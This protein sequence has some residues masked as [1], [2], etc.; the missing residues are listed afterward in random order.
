MSIAEDYKIISRLGSQ[1]RRKFGDVFLGE[2]KN[3]GR[4]VVIKAVA[5]QNNQI[6]VDRLR[7]EIS[8]SFN[9]QG[10][11]KVIDS[12]EN[13]NELF[14]VK[15]YA[16]GI[17][18]D[19]FWDKL[20]RQQ[21]IGMLKTIAPK[22]L[23]LLEILKNK[24][25]VHGDL[26]PGNILIDENDLSVHLIDFGLAIDTSQIE[27]RE[28]LFPLGFA[29]PEL[30]LNQ[31][32]LVDH[33]TDQFAFGII[34]WRLFA[35]TLPLTHPNPSIFTNLQ[36]TH[37]LPDHPNI[38]KA[39]YQ[40]LQK[41]CSKHQFQIPPNKMKNDEVKACLIQGMNSRYSTIQELKEAFTN[42]P[43]RKRWFTT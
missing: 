34:I 2:S 21:R 27:R 38:P 8:F 12:Y 29:A 6:A 23:E 30:L 40:V 43:E 1:T 11:P 32:E 25:I 15:E 20:K 10:L 5:K 9:H 39:L 41:M 36:L 35:G 24:D 33:R 7:N 22:I 16:D 37:P 42:L 28:L 3:D 4:Q 13:E 18:I 19:Q 17:P 26:K 14:L 31:L